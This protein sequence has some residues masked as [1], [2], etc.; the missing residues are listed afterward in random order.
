ME[1]S[2]PCSQIGFARYRVRSLFFESI[3]ARA[4]LNKITGSKVCPVT[5]YLIRIPPSAFTSDV[6][7]LQYSQTYFIH[8]QINRSFILQRVGDASRPNTRHCIF[9]IDIVCQMLSWW[10]KNLAD[11]INI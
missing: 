2:N 3:P 5:I 4:G 1:M 10:M 11:H 9:I 8:A 6:I 7:K